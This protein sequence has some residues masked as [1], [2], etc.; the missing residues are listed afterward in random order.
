[1]QSS[2]TVNFISRSLLIHNNKYSYDNTIFLNSNDKV[3]ITCPIHGDFKQS[4][5]NHLKGHILS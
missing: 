5:N 1:M 4:P 2:K 3:I